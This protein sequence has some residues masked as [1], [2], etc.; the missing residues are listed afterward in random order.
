MEI[1]MGDL[2]AKVGK[3][4]TG[5][6]R[7]M[8]REGC[9]NMNDN[10]ERLLEICTTY[11]LAIGGT[12]FPHPEI[13]KLTWCSPN[14]RDKNQVDQLMINGAW[15]RSL[16]DVRVRRGADVGSD[17][18]IV[19]ASLRLKL[20]KN[21]PR[22]MGQQ[23]FDVEKLRVSKARSAFILQLK[24]KFQVLADAE[25]HTEPDTTGINTMWD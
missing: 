6:E 17:H 7:A 3:D 18:H 8:G 14:G 22:E 16:L 4:N 11:D 12:L 24:N 9:G 5:Y 23:K 19:T 25:N 2:N 1:V 20:R 21:G 15:R 10:G 13:H